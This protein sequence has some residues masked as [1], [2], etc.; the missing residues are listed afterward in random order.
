MT[1][2]LPKFDDFTLSRHPHVSRFLRGVYLSNPPPV[3][4]F[5]SWRLN[6]VLT[7]LTKAPFE[8]LMDISLKWLRMKTIFLV[9]VTST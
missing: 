2:V 4:R 3:H 1:S 9:A 8:P 6:L 5:P 7:A